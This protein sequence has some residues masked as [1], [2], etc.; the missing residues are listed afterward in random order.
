MGSLDNSQV[1]TPAPLSDTAGSRQ[2]PNRPP[3]SARECSFAFELPVEMLM[4]VTPLRLTVVLMRQKRPA[5]DTPQG[6]I[7][8][9][10]RS[11]H[12]GRQP[13]KQCTPQ[14]KPATPQSPSSPLAELPLV[15]VA[16]SCPTLCNPVACSPPGSSVH[17]ILQPRILEWVTSPFLLQG[18]FPTQGLNSG[19]PHCR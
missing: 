1:S 5:L 10:L 2:N 19:L 11:E 16:Q 9:I 8:S 4:Q 18:I 17:G 14:R 7:V 13:D 15:L 3:F 12:E 6:A